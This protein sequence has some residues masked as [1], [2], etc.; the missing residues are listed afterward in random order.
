MAHK[1]TV[2][3]LSIFTNGWH[4]PHDSSFYYTPRPR[5]CVGLSAY[6]EAATMRTIEE[7]K[8]KMP[9]TIRSELNRL[10]RE[11][12]MLESCIGGASNPENS[13]LIRQ[14]IDKIKEDYPEVTNVKE[15]TFSVFESTQRQKRFKDCD[16]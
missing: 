5:A 2:Y 11:L 6:F 7:N 10:Q 12:N 4:T 8:V 1:M 15:E 9:V 13:L 14:A 3:T 16:L